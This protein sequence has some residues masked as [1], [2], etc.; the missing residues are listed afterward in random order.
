MSDSLKLETLRAGDRAAL[1]DSRG[2]RDL[3]ALGAEVVAADGQPP[4]NDQTLVDAR[5][6]RCVFTL[7]YL[8]ETLAGAAVVNGDTLELVIAPALRG[9]GL[10][11]ALTAHMLDEDKVLV[12][13]RRPHVSYLSRL[14][15]PFQSDAPLAIPTLAWSHGDHPAAA[16][17]AA[18]YR[19]SAVRRLLQLRLELESPYTAEASAPNSPAQT[20]FTIDSFVPGRDDDEW[21]ALNARVFAEHPEQGSITQSDLR[22]RI[23]EPW[24]EAGDFLVA[25]GPDGAMVGY[26]WLKIEPTDIAAAATPTPTPAAERVGEIYVI[27]V[28]PEAAGEGLGR[29]LMQHGLAALAAR[30]CT[31]AALYTDDDN[32]SAVQLYRS[33][34]FTDYTVDVQY[35]EDAHR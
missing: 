24:F 27:G 28:A 1:L 12:G 30:G 15:E 25:R 8:D 3:V 22:A 5:A 33:L 26:N 32:A 14:L 6:G 35:R 9:R 7:A 17:L 13:R 31:T 29:L 34:G 16:A 4:F 19:F 18:K 10:G 23:D 21:V 11:A 20:D 2:Y